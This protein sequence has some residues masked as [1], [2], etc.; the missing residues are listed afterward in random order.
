MFHVEK[1]ANSLEELK[2]LF[3]LCHDEIASDKAALAPNY[4][5]YLNLETL[6]GL[7]LIAAREAGELVGYY[8][9]FVAPGLHYE[10][11]LTLTTGSSMPGPGRASPRVQSESESCPAGV[12]L[13]ET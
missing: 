13:N 2:P 10:T 12:W 4:A 6:G 3:H 1:F 5:A 7:L 11:V 9:G 8:L